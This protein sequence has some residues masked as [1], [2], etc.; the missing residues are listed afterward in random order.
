MALYVY[1]LVLRR[2]NIFSVRYLTLVRVQ[3]RFHWGVLEQVGSTE[4]NMAG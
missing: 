3:R 4:A 2:R 1:G